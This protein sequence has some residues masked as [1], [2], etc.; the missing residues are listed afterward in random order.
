M[1]KDIFNYKKTLSFEVFPPKKDQD[2]YNIYQTLDNLKDLS[3]DFISV[4]YGAGGSNSKKTAKIAT[5]IKNMCDIEAIAH[6]TAVAMTPDTLEDIISTLRSKQVTNILALRGD[7]PRAMSDD[8]YMNRTYT[9]ASDLIEAISPKEEICIGAACY[10]EIHPESIDLES[11]LTNLRHKVD[12][13]VSFLI[14]QLFFDNDCFLRFLDKARSHDITVPIIP[15]IMPI[16]TASQIGT[17]V[18]LSG[19]SIPSELSNLFAKYSDSPED[20]KKAGIDYAITQIIDL[21][22]HDVDGIHIYTMNNA[23][24]A[25]SI[26]EGANL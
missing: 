5:Y 11:D 15:G 18:K 21:N 17:T 8:D 13:G 6:L 19:S 9:Y 3:P 16:T 12:T 7:R 1:I 23:N 20:M 10:P 22:K 4:T 24:I 2:I 25:K 26:C 14:T